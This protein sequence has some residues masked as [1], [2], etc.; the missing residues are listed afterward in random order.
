MCAHE[1]YANGNFTAVC[2]RAGW[3][4]QTAHVMCSNVRLTLYAANVGASEHLLTIPDA[5]DVP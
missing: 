2:G 1:C 3:A 5:W 4:P